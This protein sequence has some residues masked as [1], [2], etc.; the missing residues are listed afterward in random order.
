MRKLHKVL[1]V[2]CYWTIGKHSRVRFWHDNWLDILLVDLLPHPGSS[3]L[4]FFFVFFLSLGG[5]WNLPNCFRVTF[6]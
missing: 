6:S 5:S 1:S 2:E 3:D 4:L